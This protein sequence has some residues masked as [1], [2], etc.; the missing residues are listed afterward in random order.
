MAIIDVVPT[1]LNTGKNILHLYSGSYDTYQISA[2]NLSNLSIFIET[3]PGADTPQQL[4]NVFVIMRRSGSYIYDEFTFARAGS[5][6]I[7]LDAVEIAKYAED[8]IITCKYQGTSSYSSYKIA[9][10]QLPE[11]TPTPIN[12]QVTVTETP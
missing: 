4:E 7:F 10:R 8:N 11:I 12:V 2:E 1:L 9:F 3:T 5:I 6:E